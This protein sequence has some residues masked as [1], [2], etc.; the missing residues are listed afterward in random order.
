M[1][2]PDAVMWYRKQLCW[3]H[4]PTALS[5]DHHRGWRELGPF[6]STLP[7]VTA[8]ERRAGA[9]GCWVKGHHVSPTTCCVGGLGCRAVR[10]GAWV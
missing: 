9:K 2:P 7:C 8:T 6:P 10:P 4:S 5:P 1:K 3:D